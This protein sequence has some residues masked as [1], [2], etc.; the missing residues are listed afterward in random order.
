MALPS[1][2]ITT[3]M[4]ASAIGAATNDVGQLCIH[5]SVNMWS[6]WKPVRFN[7]VSP[8]TQ[9][10]LEA[11]NYGIA[12][13]SYAS[14]DA[15]K[16][17]YENN[18]SVLNYNKPRG[19]LYN[20]P[21]RLGDFRNYEHSAIQPI[22][23]ASVTQQAQNI[24]GGQTKI[25]GSIYINGIPKT[26][27]IGWGDLNLGSR[28]LAIALYDRNTLVK[29]AVANS[30]SDTFVEI[31]TRSPLPVLEAKRYNAFLF[32]TNNAGTTTSSLRGIPN[33][34]RFGYPVEVVSNLVLISIEAHWSESNPNEVV[35]SVKGTNQTGSPV[36]LL[37]CSIRIRNWSN[38]CTSTIQQGEVLINLGTLTLPTTG[39]G[40]PA[41]IY[42]D[43][44]TVNREQFP[45]WK[46]C[47][48][49]GGA[50]PFTTE[51]NIIQEMT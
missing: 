16:S 4:V 51:T 38:E 21:Y 28:R 22:A 40:I 19:G 25:V 49:N 8:I 11:V 31:D 30:S 5:P 34:F 29:T 35:Y 10:N 33:H 15:V 44:V 9:A 48:N 17:A 14:I 42:S 23:G 27:E 2:G 1:T 46:M 37:S 24:A 26:G 32:F 18:E 6:K 3:S 45:S 50:Y 12:W 39:G 47:W 20:E 36:S 43:S 7:S 13:N 41:T